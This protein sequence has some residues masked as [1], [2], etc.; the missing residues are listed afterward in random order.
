MA[1]RPPWH[2]EADRMHHGYLHPRSMTYCGH[3]IPLAE[4]CDS[5]SGAPLGYLPDRSADALED[6]GRAR[7]ATFVVV[8][9]LALAAVVIVACYQL[10]P[11]LQCKRL[12]QVD[13]PRADAVCAQR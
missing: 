6:R 8:V 2:P 9:L 10:A 3:G 11:D 1:T 12:Q 5:C 13:S 4:P 7:L